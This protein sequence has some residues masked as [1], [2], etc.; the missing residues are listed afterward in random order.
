MTRILVGVTVVVVILLAAIQAVP[1][2]RDHTNPPVRGEPR[3]N[4]QDTRRLAVRVCFDCHSNETVWP[5]YSKVAPVSWLT[6]RDVDEGRKALNFSEW[7]RPQEEAHEAGETVRDGEMPPW[8][9]FVTRPHARLT[10]V[11]KLALAQGLDATLGAGRR[12]KKKSRD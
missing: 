10:S 3:W 1:Y 12:E 11:E 6:Q 7:D 9:Y 5:W 4:T 2:G 8:F